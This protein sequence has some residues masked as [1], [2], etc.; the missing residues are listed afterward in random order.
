MP[1]IRKNLVSGS[2]LNSH[3]FRLVFESDKFVLSKIGMYVEKGYMSGAMW[4]LNVMTIIK[5][6][7]NKASTSAYILESSNPWHGRLGHV[8]YDTLRRL[9]NLNHIPTFQIDAK[10][11]C[12]TC[13]EAKLIRSSFQNVE[14]HTKPLDLIHND[15]CDLKFV[16]TRGGNKYFITFV[17][18]STKYCYVYLLKSKDEAIEKFVLYKHEVENQLNKKIKVL[19]SDQGGEYESPFVDVYAQHGIIDETITP[20]SP[21]SNGVVERK[22]NTL[23][24]M[25]N[26]MLISS[27]LPKNIW[28]EVILSVDYLLN[29]V[30][31]KKAEK[32]QYEL[33]RG[34]Q[35]SYKYLRVWGCLAKMAV[36]PPT[37]VKLGP[38]IVDCIF[39][40]Y[41]HNNTAYRFLV[42]ESN[43]PDIHK[44]TIMESRNASFFEDVFPCKSKE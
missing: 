16:Q 25:M 35:P 13:V 22:N 21:Q 37:M 32:T 27:T 6:D 33:W 7:M 17:D 9:I 5:S 8:N 36:P 1:K 34:R 43:I 23:K 11:K 10:H 20:C 4:K 39:I 24:E 14:R 42:H 19:R 18:D 30:P 3:G 12:G 31:K 41:A 29:K 15:M 44:N 28:E 26:A 38:K 2:L 40:D